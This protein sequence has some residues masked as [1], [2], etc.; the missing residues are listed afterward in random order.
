MKQYSYSIQNSLLQNGIISA[1]EQFYSQNIPVI[2]C[3]GTDGVVGDSLGP[4]VGTFLKE[5]NLP[6]FVYGE[7]DNPITAKHIQSIK[8]FIAKVHPDS[9]ILVIDSAVGEQEEIGII[10]ISDKG[11]KPGLGAKKDLPFLGDISIVGVV[12][13]R[14]KVEN[15][16]STRLRLVYKMAQE[17]SV[18][19]EKHIVFNMVKESKIKSLTKIGKLQKTTKKAT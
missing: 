5:K 7:L 1:L 11:I 13:K 2:V 16:K 6:A 17:I 4:L 15:L 12:E 9:K 3:V 8:D 14:G 18:A 19:I 10:K